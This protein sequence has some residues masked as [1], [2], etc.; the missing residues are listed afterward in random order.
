MK[1]L[2]PILFGLVA[3]VWPCVMG[4]QAPVQTFYEIGQGEGCIIIAQL[5]TVEESGFSWVNFLAAQVVCDY[6]SSVGYVRTPITQAKLPS[7]MLNRNQVTIAY[8]GFDPNSNSEIAGATQV[9][10]NLVNDGSEYWFSRGHLYNLSS[11]ALHPTTEEETI[12]QP[13]ADITHRVPTMEL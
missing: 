5:A 13:M 10:Q 6:K 8:G 4:Q 1:Y 11:I 12:L 3:L 9:M 2:Q 7:D